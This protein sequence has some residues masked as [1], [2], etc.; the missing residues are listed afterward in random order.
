VIVIDT[1]PIVA[2]ANR[3]DDNHEKCVELLEVFPGP[4]LLP[5]PLITEISYMLG[6]KAGADVAARAEAGFLRDIADGLYELVPVTK[7]GLRRVAAL[8]EKYKDLPLGTAD[9]CVVEVAERFGAQ[10]IATL[11]HKHFRVVRPAHIKAFTLLPED[12]D[13]NPAG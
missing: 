9:A 1:G 13:G 8:V 11:D 2:A 6:T 10:H 7:D 4:L 12:L 5:E 3:K